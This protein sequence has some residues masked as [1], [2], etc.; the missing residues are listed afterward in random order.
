M[1]PAIPGPDGFLTSRDDPHYAAHL[2]LNDYLHTEE[3]RAGTLTPFDVGVWRRIP[4]KQI[5]GQVEAVL[6]PIVWLYEHDSELDNGH[7]APTRLTTLLRVLYT[8]KIP[9]TEPGL[10]AALELTVPQSDSEQQFE[11][12]ARLLVH[13]SIFGRYFGVKPAQVE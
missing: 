4:K 6:R 12:R 13:D 3:K 1:E 11:L 9:F 8:M 2:R 10:R 5:A 7:L